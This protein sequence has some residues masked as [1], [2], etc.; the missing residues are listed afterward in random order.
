M[1]FFFS[2]LHF[3]VHAQGPGS[4]SSTSDAIRDIPVDVALPLSCALRVLGVG[5][6]L[7]HCSWPRPCILSVHQPACCW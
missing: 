3:F 4:C 2:F 6:G 7:W 5:S 1:Y